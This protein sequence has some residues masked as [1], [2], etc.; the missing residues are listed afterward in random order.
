MGSVWVARH[1]ELDVD[2]AVKLIS[3]VHALKP[4]AVE[5]FK[6]EARAAAQIRSPHVVQIMDYGIHEGVPYMAMELLAGEDLSEHLEKRG[7]VTPAR[8]LEVLRPV[9]KALG[10][11]HQA[12]IVHRDVKPAN[13]FVAKVGDDEVVKV[14]DFGI[15]KETSRDAQHTTGTGLVGSPMYMSPEQ[16]RGSDVDHQS[17][18]WSLAVVLYELLAGSTPFEAPALPHLFHMVSNTDAPPI[19]S[20]VAELTAFDAFFQRGLSREKA[21]RFATTRD[22]LEAFEEACKRAPLIV[23]PE[24]TP[25]SIVSARSAASSSEALAPTAA[26]GDA[27]TRV[28]P[29]T[30]ASNAGTLDALAELPSSAE[31]ARPK[32]RSSSKLVRNAVIVGL[33][34]GL[35]GGA[36]AIVSGRLERG[37]PVAD[38][39]AAQSEPVSGPAA[40]S[41][42]SGGIDVVAATGT[43]PAA[44]QATASVSASVS[45]NASASPQA[46]APTVPPRRPVGRTPPVPPKPTAAPQSDQSTTDPIWG[47]E[48]SKPKR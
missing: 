41:D 1:V 38:P 29:R 40:G 48:V 27:A 34:L 21:A 15:A 43:P 36:A 18:L 44:Q 42:T 26:L 17:D 4:V 20:K 8:A 16:I 19:S 7:R 30:P 11:A 5:R 12:G 35:A 37:G 22:L 24:M 10:L 47:V 3:W 9:C 31:L 32:E 28:D 33:G 23:I 46:A 39:V 25:V 6:R 13:I 14:L 45:A 2:V